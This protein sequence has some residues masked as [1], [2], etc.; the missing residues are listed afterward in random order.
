MPPLTA[1]AA[2]AQ[3]GAGCIQ[4]TVK[5]TTDAVIPNARIVA[6]HLETGTRFTTLSNRDGFF[7]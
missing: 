1:F 4:S 5:D 2:S 3:T 7:A 6:E